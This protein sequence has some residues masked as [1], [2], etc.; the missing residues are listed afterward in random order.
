VKV[1]S[2]LSCESFNVKYKHFVIWW[3][4]I[5]NSLFVLSNILKIDGGVMARLIRGRGT[6][7]N[8]LVQIHEC[9]HEYLSWNLTWGIDDLLVRFIVVFHIYIISF[10][11][12]KMKTPHYYWAIL[13]SFFL[14]FGNFTLPNCKVEIAQFSSILHVYILK[15]SIH[16]VI[17]L[18]FQITKSLSPYGLPKWASTYPQV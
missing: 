14:L 2:I 1:I 18:F 8:V 11:N 4:Q 6:S 16:I 12:I 10:W 15:L 13:P 17:L 5:S 3:Y 9:V 7:K